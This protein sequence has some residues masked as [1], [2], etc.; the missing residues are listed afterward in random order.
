MADDPTIEPR[1]CTI[2]LP[3]HSLQG[4]KTSLL[5]DEIFPA[6]PHR[7]CPINLLIVLDNVVWNQGLGGLDF[8]KLPV[9]FPVSREFRPET[10]SLLTGSSAMHLT[11]ITPYFQFPWSTEKS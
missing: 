9:N 8:P 4:G 1:I 7:N 2:F 3:N 5:K 11:N 6:W 10:G